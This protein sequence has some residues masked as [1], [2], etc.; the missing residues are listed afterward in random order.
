MNDI[1]IDGPQDLYLRLKDK[2]DLGPFSAFYAKAHTLNDP[3]TCSCKKG[4]NA[5]NEM[6]R[7]FVSIPHNIRNEPNLSV[8][9]RLLGEGTLIFRMDGLELTRIG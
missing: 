3:G 4:K 5:Q 8:A 6:K 7:L 9:R 2:Q 1:V